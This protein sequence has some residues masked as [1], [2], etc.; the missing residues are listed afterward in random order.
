MFVDRREMFVAECYC[1]FPRDC[2]CPR[3]DDNRHFRI[4]FGDNGVSID[5]IE[6][7]RHFRNATNVV[8]RQFHGNDVMRVRTKADT[9]PSPPAARPDAVFLIEPLALAVNFEAGAIDRKMQRFRAI[10]RF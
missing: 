6:Q 7:V 1:G 10:D 8:R 2:R 9:R 3:R 4:T 5:L